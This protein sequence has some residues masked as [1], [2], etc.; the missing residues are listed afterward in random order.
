MN[1]LWWIYIF[2]AFLL[3]YGVQF[4]NVHTFFD[5]HLSLEDTKQ[6]QGF[7]VIGVIL[8]HLVQKVTNFGQTDSILGIFNDLG[9]YFVGIFFFF[10]G[11]G[12]YK[13]LRSKKGYLSNFFKKR[14]ATILLP[15]YIISLIYFFINLAE[16][17]K[18]NPFDALLSILGFR[19]INGDF[20]FI[21]AILIFYLLFYLS[22]RFLKN[23]NLAILAI[24]FGIL[25][26]IVICILRVHGDGTFWLQGE[27][28]YNTSLLFLFGILWG[29]FE[30]RFI[31][32]IKKFYW[33]ILSSFTILF[34][35]SQQI[36]RN[37]LQH[38]GYWT[39]TATDPKY[40]DK[41]QCFLVQSAS[42]ILFVLLIVIITLKI[43]FKNSALKFIGGITL[44]IYLLQR[45][46]ILQFAPLQS[47]FI[48]YTLSVICT[49]ILVS[50]SIHHLSS[51]LK[52]SFKL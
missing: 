11:F 24:G 34:I 45:L 2:L 26:Y 12:L 43:K 28:W 48:M 52:K 31:F 4:S 29:K 46:F 15:F 32:Y 33:A 22:F 49:S 39:E 37:T 36:T 3:L 8:H 50:F 18:Y 17:V 19:L 16:G 27:W 6:L 40:F 38:I 47:N 41:I 10:S 21:I 51:Y 20:W 35:L 42:I 9:V 25:I 44:E 23:E 1:T 30:H 14:F 13:S 7:A 5:D